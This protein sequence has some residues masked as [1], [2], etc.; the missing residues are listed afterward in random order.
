MDDPVAAVAESIVGHIRKE[1]Y[2]AIAR[3][4][5]VSCDGEWRRELR[6]EFDL[7]RTLE[8]LF[9]NDILVPKL[10]L[11]DVRTISPFHY[12]ALRG[13]DFVLERFIVRDRVPVDLCVESGST[14]LHFAAFAGALDTVAML[15]ERFH[16]DVNRKDRYGWTALH[17]ASTEGNLPVIEYLVRG[18]ADVGVRDK[19]GTTA[20]FRAQAVGHATVV[21]YFVRTSGD[22]DLLLVDDS[23][24]DSADD[25]AD[26]DDVYST[27]DSSRKSGKTTNDED[28]KEGD[29]SR[30]YETSANTTTT[31]DKST[32]RGRGDVASLVRDQLNEIFGDDF[33]PYV[34]PVAKGAGGRVPLEIGV[35]TLTRILKDEFLKFK[36]DHEVRKATDSKP[37]TSASSD[38]AWPDFAPPDYEDI[39]KYAKG[40]VRSQDFNLSQYATVVFDAP[41][42]EVDPPPPLPPRNNPAVESSKPEAPPGSSLKN[43]KKPGNRKTKGGG[44]KKNLGR[45]NYATLT[46]ADVADRHPAKTKALQMLD[47]FD[48][49]SAVM[50]A[51]FQALVENLGDVEDWKRLSAALPLRNRPEAVHD[52]IR[53][54]E[55]QHPAN[56]RKQAIGALQDWRSHVGETADVDALVEA[57]KQ[58][59]LE[60]KVILVETA[61]QEFNV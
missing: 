53:T 52:R 22:D 43:K 19:D 25:D 55:M 44:G 51:C 26:D 24:A 33:D 6:Y 38:T 7:E 9:R 32:A 54:I 27:I 39:S 60:D 5:D 31:I 21:S 45:T 12:A 47:R 34:N 36:V 3:N 2:E 35:N 61:A 16:A 48:R 18:G 41:A 13:F 1:D 40:T 23:S 29:S 20:A 4:L 8:T 57:M 10:I 14:A 11:C 50:D 46:F 42:P 37:D 30:Y 28:S 58:C 56:P 17:Y 49:S 15:V 59:G